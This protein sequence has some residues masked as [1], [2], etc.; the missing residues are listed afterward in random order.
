MAGERN[1][2]R[3]LRAIE[4][5]KLQANSS[6]SNNAAP[7]RAT[8]SYRPGQGKSEDPF[9]F[10]DQQMQ[11]VPEAERHLKRRKGAD[12]DFYRPSVRPP[13]LSP[14][15]QTPET[16]TAFLH[17]VVAHQRRHSPS[18]ANSRPPIP[19]EAE[20]LSKAKGREKK[21]RTLQSNIHNLQKQLS[22]IWL[23][24]RLRMDAERT[25]ASYQANLR[26]KYDLPAKN[27]PKARYNTVRAIERNHAQKMLSKTKAKEASLEYRLKIV[28]DKLEKDIP[29]TVSDDHEEGGVSLTQYS[30]T[31]NMNLGRRRGFDKSKNRRRPY[32]NG[33][34]FVKN[35]AYA[36]RTQKE[37][38]GNLEQARQ[39]SHVAEVDANYCCFAPLD[40]PYIC[41]F[42]TDEQGRFLRGTKRQHKKRVQAEVD[43]EKEL[44]K[45]T[46]AGILR[47]NLG[48][49]PP[50]WIEIDE[51][52]KAGLFQGLADSLGLGID[53]HNLTE[54][55]GK[56]DALERAIVGSTLKRRHSWM[57]DNEIAPEDL[58]SESESQSDIDDDD[59]NDDDDEDDDEV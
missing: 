38:E 54:V 44:Q 43:P 22:G 34:E 10:D 47:T 24:D 19:P 23:N 52:M 5:H 6:V 32:V 58:D 33:D 7:N 21:L 42:P 26:A 16:D 55:G 56:V 53:E 4:K 31:D 49:K 1:R 8:D 12:G 37:L 20:K 11:D 15:K 36:R 30:A 40:Q 17:K 46:E 29:V 51:K 35:P 18:P 45:D 2:A 57:D 14:Y 59:D 27:N 9:Y 13:L 41:L 3:R 39:Q 50:L 48:N 25:L 28:R